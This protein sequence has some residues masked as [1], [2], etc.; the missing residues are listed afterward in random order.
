MLRSGRLRAL[1][2]LVRWLG[3]WGSSEAIPPSIRREDW[4]LREGHLR[5]KRSG[6]L[7]S[8]PPSQGPSRLDAWVYHP[9]GSSI[10]TYLVAHG[11][12]FLG[13]EDVRLD[14]FCRILAA[15]GFRVV[16]PFIPDYL[17]LLLRPSVPDDLE[18][19]ARAVLERFGSAPTLFAISFGAWPALE[20]AARLGERVDGVISFG[21]YVEAEPT[22]RFCADGIMRTPQGNVVL[23][24]SLRNLPALFLNLVHHMDS[25]GGDP[26]VL[27]AAWRD[28]AWRIW[29]QEKFDQ[30]ATVEPVARE[31]AWRLPESQRELFLRGCGV[32][33]GAEELANELLTRASEWMRFA[34]AGPALQ[35][36]TCPVVACHGRGDDVIP[37]NESS[38]LHKTLAARVP[39]R[40]YLTG[41]YGHT[42]A[43][44]L[45]LVQ[46]AGEAATL[47]QI[48]WAMAQGGR[49]RQYLSSH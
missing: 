33:P 31:V 42:G 12:H 43:N 6:Q 49:L 39:S 8:V 9:Q 41:M 27:E 32:L 30:V 20:V 40:L 19:C 26:A 14:R 5:G 18:A 45:P 4:L 35:R 11:L 7:L 25:P 3:P 2:A 46:L 44:Q 16:A 17:D 48:S 13:P 15:A 28:M 21:G 37:W 24:R 10:G 36:L 1:S 23:S 29:G 38:K 22:L 47:L 34:D